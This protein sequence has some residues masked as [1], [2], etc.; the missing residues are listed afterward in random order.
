VHEHLFLDTSAQPGEE[1]HDPDKAVE[2][3]LTLRAG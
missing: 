2:E 1:F 3:A